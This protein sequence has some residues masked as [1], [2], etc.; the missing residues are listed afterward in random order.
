MGNAEK[1]KMIPELDAVASMT[2]SEIDTLVRRCS[3]FVQEYPQ[4]EEI[5]Q[6]AITSGDRKLFLKHFTDLCDT[7]DRIGANTFVT[8]RLRAF[9]NNFLA[10]VSC[11][12]IDIQLA[13]YSPNDAPSS[14]KIMKQ[15]LHGNSSVDLVAPAILAVEVTSFFFS[16]LKRIF[17]NTS[18]RLTCATSCDEALSYAKQNKPDLLLISADMP[19]ADCFELCEKIRQTGC[20]SPIILLVGAATESVVTKAVQAGLSDIMI[21]SVD[22]AQLLKRVNRYFIKNRSIE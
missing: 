18:Y 6:N 5:I 19:G 10:A 11:L 8:N 12:S 21:K 22:D 16:F 15:I 7:L 17:E 3:K 2:D 1:L 14:E 20:N 4:T 9:S 13:S